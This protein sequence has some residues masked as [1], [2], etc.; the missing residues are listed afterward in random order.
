MLGGELGDGNEGS[1]AAFPQIID[2][3]LSWTPRRKGVEPA[4]DFDAELR[5]LLNNCPSKIR[6]LACLQYR[7]CREA[8]TPATALI[9]RGSRFTFRGVLALA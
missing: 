6:T 7:W 2:A 1:L 4:N 3:H 8:G 5:A 9:F